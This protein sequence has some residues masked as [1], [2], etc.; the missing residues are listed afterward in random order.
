MEL[1]LNHRGCCQLIASYGGILLMVST[2]YAESFGPVNY[3][4]MKINC[5]LEAY[6]IDINLFRRKLLWMGKWRGQFGVYYVHGSKNV[7][8]LKA[9]SPQ[10][11]KMINWRALKWCMGKQG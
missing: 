9:G 7:S 1:L 3:L 8:Q 10:E 11:I 2:G 6:L 4:K 5:H